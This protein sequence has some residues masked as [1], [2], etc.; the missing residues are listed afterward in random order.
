MKLCEPIS[1]SNLRKN[2]KNTMPVSVNNCSFISIRTEHAHNIIFILNVIHYYSD[3]SSS[4]YFIDESF[5]QI[6]S[7]Q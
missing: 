5:R 1:I 2:Q 7:E 3:H 4:C 6:L